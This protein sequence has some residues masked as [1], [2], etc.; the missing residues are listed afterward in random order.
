M[1]SGIELTSLDGEVTL[2]FPEF[3]FYCL[4]SVSFEV[5]PC[6][7]CLGTNEFMKIEFYTFIHND[8]KYKISE[9]H[10]MLRDD[11]PEIMDIHKQR[12]LNKS[13]ETTHYRDAVKKLTGHTINQPSPE[14]R[15]PNDVLGVKKYGYGGNPIPGEKD[16]GKDKIR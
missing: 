8:K 16:P 7:S 1:L 11:C 3:S 10:A 13:D 2:I 12:V 6:N 15:T 14:N 9:N 5:K 4:D